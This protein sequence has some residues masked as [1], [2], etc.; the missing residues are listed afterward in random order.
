VRRVCFGLHAFTPT[1]ASGRWV[2]GG[3]ARERSRPAFPASSSHGEGTAR[4]RPGRDRRADRRSRRRTLL[5]DQTDSRKHRPEVDTSFHGHLARVKT[6]VAQTLVRLSTP[7]QAVALATSITYRHRRQ[8]E[9][10]LLTVGEAE[11]RGGVPSLRL[12]SPGRLLR[13]AQRRLWSRHA[14]LEL[15]LRRGAR[16]VAGTTFGL[17]PSWRAVPSG[18]WSEGPPDII[19]AGRWGGGGGG[20]RRSRMGAGVGRGC[21]PADSWR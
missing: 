4:Q 2:R 7:M 6:K 19:N 17:I 9:A 3:D 15:G 21:W 18:F 13:P 1:I 10:E 12:P 20:S 16:A 5:S 8:P 14:L 11:W